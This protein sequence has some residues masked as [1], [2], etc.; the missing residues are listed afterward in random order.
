LQAQLQRLTGAEQCQ[1]TVARK[2]R[3]V[4]VKVVRHRDGAHDDIQAG[5]LPLHRGFG[6]GRLH[7][8]VLDHL[9]VIRVAAIGECTCLCVLAILERARRVLAV[10]LQFQGAGVAAPVRTDEAAHSGE[11]ACLA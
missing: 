11:V 3:D 8:D 10:L 5:R 9:D 4:G 6:L 1:D 7:H 2:A